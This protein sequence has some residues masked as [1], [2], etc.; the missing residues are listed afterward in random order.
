MLDG[1]TPLY[2]TRRAGTAERRRSGRAT[3]IIAPYKDSPQNLD[4]IIFQDPFPRSSTNEISE[5]MT[6][7]GRTCAVS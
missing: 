6:R 4:C 2:E 1:F 3:F 5:I 7:K